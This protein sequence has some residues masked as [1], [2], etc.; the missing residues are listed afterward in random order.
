MIQTHLIFFYPFELLMN[1]FGDKITYNTM[2]NTLKQDKAIVDLLDKTTYDSMHGKFSIIYDIFS[3]HYKCNYKNIMKR[4][5]LVFKSNPR[6][7]K[8]V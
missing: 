7:F 3:N 6:L 4:I 2:F 8:N 1:I 5:I